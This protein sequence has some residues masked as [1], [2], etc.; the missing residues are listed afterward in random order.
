MLNKTYFTNR[1]PEFDG[2]RA[3]LLDA[4]KSNAAVRQDHFDCLMNLIHMMR[5]QLLHG[6]PCSPDLVAPLP[7]VPWSRL[8]IEGPRPDASIGVAPPALVAWCPLALEK[9]RLVM[10]ISDSITR[11]LGSSC[12]GPSALISCPAGA[13]ASRSIPPEIA[14]T[15]FDSVNLRCL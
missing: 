7:L 2:N 14:S 13:G 15:A 5:Q 12:L 6:A 4:V 11:R 9:P 8:V 3:K 1:Y 10:K